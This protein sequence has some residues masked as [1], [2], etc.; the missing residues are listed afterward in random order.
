MCVHAG[1]RVGAIC[2]HSRKK[3]ELSQVISAEE[4]A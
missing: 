4:R 3:I 2:E 1:R